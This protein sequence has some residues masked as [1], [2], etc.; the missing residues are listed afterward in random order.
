MRHDFIYL[1]MERL[2]TVI[3]NKVDH[4]T[5]YDEQFTLP[6][7]SEVEMGDKLFV[8]TR[9]KF[10]ESFFKET[11]SKMPAIVHIVE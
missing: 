3:W 11:D 5:I 9:V 4:F 6:V 8:V 7:G 10:V 2:K 1:A